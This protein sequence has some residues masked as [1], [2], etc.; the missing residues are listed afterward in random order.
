MAALAK[1][2]KIYKCHCNKRCEVKVLSDFG[3]S[4]LAPIRPHVPKIYKL[5]YN[6]RNMNTK[7]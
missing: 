1:N 6:N 7:T 2:M 5:S 4:L 3:I